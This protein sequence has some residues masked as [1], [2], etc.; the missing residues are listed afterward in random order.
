M[1]LFFF[2]D[3]DSDQLRENCCSIM[4][5][6]QQQQT[7]QQQLKAHSQKVNRLRGSKNVSAPPCLKNVTYIFEVI[8]QKMIPGASTM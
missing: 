3:G 1:L 4:F 6:F 2:V 5:A 8:T 7:T